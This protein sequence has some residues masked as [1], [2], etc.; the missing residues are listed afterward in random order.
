[1]EIGRRRG[2]K[3]GGENNPVH[4]RNSHWFRVAVLPGM[5]ETWERGGQEVC[6]EAGWMGHVN[7][8]RAVWT[9]GHAR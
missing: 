2:P 3:P 9:K 1:M 8:F 6:C 7:R 5:K 4:L